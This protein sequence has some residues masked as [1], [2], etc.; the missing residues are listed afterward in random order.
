MT[1]II[2]DLRKCRWLIK[3]RYGLILTTCLLGVVLALSVNL[4]TPPT[5]EAVTSLRV[6]QS[7]GV[8]LLA[9]MA[10][11]SHLNIK[12]AMANYAALL[13]SRTVVQ[14]AIDQIY[15]DKGISPQY[16]QLIPNITIKPAKE[17]DI[18]YITVQSSSPK[19]AQLLANT[20]GE[21][22]VSLLANEQGVVREFIGQRLKDSKQELEQA[23]GL[24]EKYKRDQKMLGSDIQ[25][26]A[27]AEKLSALDKM[28]AENTVNLVTAQAKLGNAERQLA[29]QK[30]GLVAD[31]SLIQQHKSKL[32]DLE[33]ELASISPKYADNHPKVV[34]LRA[35]ITETRSKL[36]AEVAR[37][38]NSEAASGN[39]INQAL[40]QEKIMAEADIAAASAQKRVIGNILANSEK[41]MASL[42]A[43]EQGITR[44]M[45]DAQVA[46][47]IY[48][49]LDKRYEEARIN[50]V[51]QPRDVK[52]LDA[53]IAPELPIKSR[54]M[55]ILLIGAV[56]G[57]LV[58]AAIAFLVEYAKRPI[59]ND[60]EAKGL[61]GLP[62]L[63][64]IP[65][66]GAD[67]NFPR[68]SFGNKV[69]RFFFLD[70]LKLK[71]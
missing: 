49:M 69:R 68:E 40:L 33:V 17:A 60:Q 15:Q 25:S 55:L 54:K 42:P 32:A 21:T 65:D 4:T 62:V 41:D 66:F 53:A 37:V 61:L 35:A 3:E 39:P 11:G 28:V 20:L 18:L 23:E 63:G 43:K 8:P 59:L 57:L 52:V 44:L 30:P 7:Q 27:M 6:N 45:R 67:I 50:E 38:L 64:I 29:G 14:A 56:L 13:K 34:S 1:Q 26:R 5:Y 51:M 70:R 31:N 47:E 71:R 10:G 2:S 19:E 46:Q 22:L 36:N 12:Q 16:E 24:L 58:G 48:I 9:D